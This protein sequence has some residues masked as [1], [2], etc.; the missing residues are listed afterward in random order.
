M[1]QAIQTLGY[2]IY[3]CWYYTH[4]LSQAIQAYRY[5]NKEITYSDDLYDLIKVQ[6]QPNYPC[7]PKMEIL[8]DSFQKTEIVFLEI[9]T[10]KNYEYNGIFLNQECNQV[11]TMSCVKLSHD[12]KSDLLDKMKIIESMYHCPVVFVPHVY[13]DK[14]LKTMPGLSVRK[15]IEDAVIEFC[16]Q[17]DNRFMFIPSVVINQYG[18]EM[19]LM[20]KS[21]Q[22]D[23]NHYSEFGR[24]IIAK[25]FE[26]IIQQ[27]VG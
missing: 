2:P 3:E 10:N 12:S 14:W 15:G 1:Q 21:G 20:T 6:G 27:I 25:E 9:Q 11:K 4:T 17:A 5:F 16:S 24:Y 22:V 19:M 7:H 26:K 23:P 8:I 18:D 13:S